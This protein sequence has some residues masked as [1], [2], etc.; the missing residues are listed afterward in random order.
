MFNEYKA[1]TCAWSLLI[2]VAVAL[3]A[4]IPWGD[5][6]GRLSHLDEHVL[7]KTR[8]RNPAYYAVG[9]QGYCAC[10]NAV[11]NRVCVCFQNDGAICVECGGLAALSGVAT[12]PSLPGSFIIP[13]GGSGS[14]ENLQ[15]FL[16]ICEGLKCLD[17]VDQDKECTGTYPFFVEET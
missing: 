2:L 7:A 17:P 9:G 1:I 4:V 15:L 16:G 10:A 11:N 6:G 14:C 8:G 12:P 3:N 13:A 5:L